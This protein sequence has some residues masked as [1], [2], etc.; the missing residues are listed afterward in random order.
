METGKKRLRSDYLVR[1]EVNR[2]REAAEQH[3]AEIAVNLPK[4]QR[5]A[6]DDGYGCQPSGMTT[7]ARSALS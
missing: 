5:L 4:Q 3:A 7:C 2:I 1:D 6:L